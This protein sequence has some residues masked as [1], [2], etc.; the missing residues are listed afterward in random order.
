MILRD[1]VVQRGGDYRLAGGYYELGFDLTMSIGL[2]VLLRAIIDQTPITPR[3]LF[4]IGL[5]AGC[6]SEV[7]NVVGRLAEE[8]VKLAAALLTHGSV[9]TVNFLFVVTDEL[10]TILAMGI[11]SLALLSAA[12]APSGKTFVPRFATLAASAAVTSVVVGR[13]IIPGVL[14]L[15]GLHFRWDDPYR[16]AMEIVSGCILS[17]V[18]G[19]AGLLGFRVSLRIA[20]G[21]RPFPDWPVPSPTGET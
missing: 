1:F 13:F 20:F 14:N 16:L 4:R 8:M 17:T 9:H 10:P 19:L 11:L 6:V 21:D 7:I 15:A 2:F 3:Y 5:F 12:M 18:A